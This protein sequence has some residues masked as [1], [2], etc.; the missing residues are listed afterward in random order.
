MKLSAV[1]SL[2]GCSINVRIAEEALYSVMDDNTGVLSPEMVMKDVA[3]YFKIKVSD[4]KSPKRNQK[5]TTPRHVAMYLC[6]ELCQMSFPEI[7]RSFGK[8]DHSTVMHACRKIGINKNTDLELRR[9]LQMLM[10]KIKS[11]EF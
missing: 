5:F 11:E 10:R 1:S 8:R 7:G 6:R 9:H 4:L 2:Y 3:G